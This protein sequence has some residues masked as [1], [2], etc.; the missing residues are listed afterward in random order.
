MVLKHIY[1]YLS[2]HDTHCSFMKKFVKISQKVVP[3]FPDLAVLENPQMP[4]Y[5]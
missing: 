1:K 5:P 3:S 4:V 2:C